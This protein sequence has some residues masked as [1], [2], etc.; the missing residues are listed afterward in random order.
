MRDNIPKLMEI[1]PRLWG[2]LHLAVKSGINFPAM[3][4]QLALKGDVD[5][6]FDYREGIKLRW[7][8]QGD[9]LSFASSMIRKHNIDWE[10]FKFHE[11]DMHYAILSLSD[12]LP[13]LGKMLSLIDYCTS[14]EMRRFHG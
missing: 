13:V 9:L 6:A 11:K 4:H 5:D 14:E 12:P 2:S 3:L 7:L 10:F 8:I 1:N